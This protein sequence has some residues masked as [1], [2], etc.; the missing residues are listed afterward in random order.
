MPMFTI[1]ATRTH[2]YEVEVEALNEED[3]Y[4]QL[5]EWIA[6]DFEEYETNA[7]WEFNI[8]EKENN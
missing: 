8:T 5:D 7:Q 4:R 6:D 2:W 1:E 3:A